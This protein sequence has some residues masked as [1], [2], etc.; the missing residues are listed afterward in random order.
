MNV[1]LHASISFIY[2]LM[3]SNDGQTVQNWVPTVLT[4]SFASKEIKV[5]WGKR[6]D[7]VVLNYIFVLGQNALSLIDGLV[8]GPRPKKNV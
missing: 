1:D 8:V 3:L 6:L 4:I 7:Y 2:I 5:K